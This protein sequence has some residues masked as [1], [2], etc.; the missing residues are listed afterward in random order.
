MMSASVASSVVLTISAAV[1]PSSP[2]RM[3]RGPSKRKEKPRAG[4]SICGEETPIS[5]VTPSTSVT[6]RAVSSR[7][8]SPKRPLKSSSL[9]ECFATRVAPAAIARGSRSMPQTRQR[10]AASSAAE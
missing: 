7:S 9:P 2:M 6:P 3:S 8:M 1:G 4:S 5:S 10:A